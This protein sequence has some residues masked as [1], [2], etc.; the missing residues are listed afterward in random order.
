M[1]I[2]RSSERA[3]IETSLLNRRPERGGVSPALRSGRG[4]K[5]TRAVAG[6][7]DES[8]ARSSE[9]ARIETSLD[10]RLS[11]LLSVSPALRSGRGLKQAC[12]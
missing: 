2:A 8:I 7:N 6:P 12:W 10:R 5:R 9:R 3:R 1:R 11:Q 4:L